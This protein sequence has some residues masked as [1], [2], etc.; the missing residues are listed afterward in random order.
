[1]PALTIDIIHPALTSQKEN[2]D[3]GNLA[4]DCGIFV[5]KKKRS[6]SA[7]DPVDEIYARHEPA[8]YPDI[9]GRF[10]Y[11]DHQVGYPSFVQV[12]A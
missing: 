5:H 1:V 6:C 12:G 4:T 2:K 8:L 7:A 11:Y 9:P 10:D 3:Y